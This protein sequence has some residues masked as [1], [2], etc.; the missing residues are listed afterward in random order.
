[1]APWRFAWWSVGAALITVAL[2]VAAWRVS[3]AV[4]MFADAAE[5][6]VNLVAAGTTLLLLRWSAQ[7]AD[8]DHPHGHG[9]A[10]HIAAGF[11][12]VLVLCAGA[13][14]AAA[15]LER[16]MQP[17]PVQQLALG[18]AL[19]AAATLVNLGVGL[20]LVRWGRAHESSALEADG[21]HLLSDVWTSVAVLLGLGLAAVTGWPW[22]D[23]ALGLLVCG[24]VLW[25][26][27]GILRSAASGLLDERLPADEQL[28]V[29]RV[30]GEF[31]AAHPGIEIHALRTRRS[32]PVRFATMH[33]LVP[34]GWSV[35][36]GHDL[37]DVLEHRVEALFA[38]ASVLTH[39]EPLEDEG[40]R[41]DTHL[42]RDRRSTSA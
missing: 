33:V 20:Q 19:T 7:P 29:E 5:G 23:P 25:T 18:S 42:I 24:V 32:G 27:R 30:I 12:G 8:D 13:G 6:L 2:K 10:E 21:H 41:S 26:A 39:L 1:M 40:A 31:V 34:G 15:S 16:F 3:G 22:L 28:Q 11:E 4:S 9:K 36:R 17:Q 37:C 35:A 38:T 14:I